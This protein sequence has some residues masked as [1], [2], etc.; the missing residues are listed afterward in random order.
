VITLKDQVQFI[1][2]GGMVRRFHQHPQLVQ[3]TDG[4][5]SHGV[6]ML[7]FLLSGGEPSRELLIAALT[8]DLAEQTAGDVPA[9]TKRAM[10]NSGFDLDGYETI[11][12][13]ANGF[14]NEL[15]PKEHR[16]LKIADALDGMLACCRE[17]AMGNRT[18]V[19]IY[20]KWVIWM[21][22]DFTPLSDEEQKIVGVVDDIWR[23]VLNRDDAGY[24]DNAVVDGATL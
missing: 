15:T 7:C 3:D 9:P 5:H 2:R 1:S 11:I 16:T 21:T 18:V 14:E 20:R 22:A 4:R 13:R 10:R 24:R 12:L 17:L 8:H 19:W 23:D 6:A